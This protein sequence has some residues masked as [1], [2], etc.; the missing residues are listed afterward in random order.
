MV[1]QIKSHVLN[2]GHK[3][4]RVEVEQRR[5]DILRLGGG[6]YWGTV[7]RVLYFFRL[8]FIVLWVLAQNNGTGGHGLKICIPGFYIFRCCVV[9]RGG[10]RT[11]LPA[12][13]VLIARTEK[14]DVEPDCVGVR[15]AE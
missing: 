4:L 3:L 9:S 12:L 2:L 15:M 11:T 14:G 6:T 10:A 1:L 5:G 8:G 13:A 7:D